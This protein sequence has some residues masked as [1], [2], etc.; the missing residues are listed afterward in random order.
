MG[1][2]VDWQVSGSGRSRQRMALVEFRTTDGEL[3]RTATNLN[4][5]AIMGYSAGDALRVRF[6]AQHPQECIIDEQQLV[7]LWFKLT[8][9]I[10]LWLL[11]FA[12]AGIITWQSRH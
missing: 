1:R 7:P 5:S 8:L 6:N 11:F 10:L 4:T 9:I 2:L 12:G 3:I